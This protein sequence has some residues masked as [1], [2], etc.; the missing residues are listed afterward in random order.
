ME[1]TFKYVFY[2]LYT[3]VEEIITKDKLHYE[4]GQGVKVR[5]DFYRIDEIK[6]LNNLDLDQVII[7][8]RLVSQTIEDIGYPFTELF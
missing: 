8:L 3:I 7:S 6:V 5:E 4:V 2:D 1:L